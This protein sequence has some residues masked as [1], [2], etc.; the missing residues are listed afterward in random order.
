M[1]PR[2]HCLLT[3]PPPMAQQHSLLLTITNEVDC[4]VLHCCHPSSWPTATIII[5]ISI[6]H[7]L[8]SSFAPLLAC[9]PPPPSPI[10]HCCHRHRHHLRLRL[11]PSSN[12]LCLI[13]VCCRSSSLFI[14][15]YSPFS[16]SRSLP[17][18]APHSSAPAPIFLSSL[19]LLSRL[20]DCCMHP[21]QIRLTL[22]LL[23]RRITNV[24]LGHCCCRHH[25]RRHHGRRGSDVHSAGDGRRLHRRLHRRLCSRAAAGDGR[26][27]RCPH[28]H[29]LLLLLC[30]GHPDLLLFG[31]VT[32]PP[33]KNRVHSSRSPP[34]SLSERPP[35][36][37]SKR[38][39][40][41]W[42]GRTESGRRRRLHFI[43]DR[44]RCYRFPTLPNEVCS[45]QRT[46][47]RQLPVCS[48]SR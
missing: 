9:V 3:P 2:R 36:S 35:F 32:D 31:G 13:V 40:V 29:P 1:K 44:C 43:S 23:R 48:V 47:P 45:L 12:V 27:P 10:F 41:M 7:L 4:C 37:L 24:Q 17:A 34:L 11:S 26:P 20:F 5:V 21:R 15:V 38:F 16:S 8:A 42:V 14:L 19:L 25:H 46:P 28:P 30:R 18:P 6:L 39:I 33:L 22:F